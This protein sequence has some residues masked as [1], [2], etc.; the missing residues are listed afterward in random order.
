MFGYYP[1]SFQVMGHVDHGKTTLLD[2]LRNT[3]VAEGEAGGITQHI[4]AFTV[5][6]ENG[7]KVTFLDTPG[8]AAFSEFSTF[9]IKSIL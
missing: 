2:S 3:S 9:S 8:H 7:E 1:L 6:L 5:E 4:G